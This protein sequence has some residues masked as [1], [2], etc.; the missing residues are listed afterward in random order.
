MNIDIDISMGYHNEYL[1]VIIHMCKSSNHG[2]VAM[3]RQIRKSAWILVEGF[4]TKK[5][6]GCNSSIMGIFWDI[7]SGLHVYITVKNDPPCYEWKNS[8]FLGPW[9]PVRYVTQITRPG[10]RHPEGCLERVPTGGAM[11]GIMWPDKNLCK[12]GM[13]MSKSDSRIG[14]CLHN[15]GKSQFLSIS[16]R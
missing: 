5:T 10:N 7:P 8:L 12:D 9:L 1:N 6:P 14:K 11:A 3:F 4:I 13:V 15:Y 2:K 16:N